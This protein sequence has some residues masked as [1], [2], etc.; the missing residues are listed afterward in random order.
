MTQIYHIC[1]KEALKSAREAGSYR[2]E[3]LK[4][5]GFIHFSQRHQVLGVAGAFYR[6][7][8]DLVILVVD[9][10]RVKA[11]I[12][13]EAPIHP[14]A[15]DSA[16]SVIPSNDQQFPHLYGELNIDAVV[17][18]IELPLLSS[19]DFDTSVFITAS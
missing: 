16:R 14:G 19:G 2:T 15:V 12:R 8:K 7:Q 4:T 11:V 1:S 18:V 10:N 9:E 17:N 13:Y 5:E 6:G 3:S